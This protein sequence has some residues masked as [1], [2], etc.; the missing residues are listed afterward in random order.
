MIKN[1]EQIVQIF[2]VLYLYLN[3]CLVI[4]VILRGVFLGKSCVVI[5]YDFIWIVYIF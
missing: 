5:V 1:D 3:W 4:G 2:I